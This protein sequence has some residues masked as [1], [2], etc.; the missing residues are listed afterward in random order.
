[1]KDFDLTGV[2][3]SGIEDIDTCSP[4]DLPSGLRRGYFLGGVTCAL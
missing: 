1:M 2:R 4:P 3:K